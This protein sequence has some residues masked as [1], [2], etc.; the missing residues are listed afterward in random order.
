ML[1]ACR[2]YV[3]SRNQAPALIC[4]VMKV[5]HWCDFK[6]W[7]VSPKKCYCIKKDHLLLSLFLQGGHWDP[8]NPDG[9]FNPSGILFLSSASLTVGHIKNRRKYWQHPD[10][11]V[12]AG[13]SWSCFHSSQLML[14]RR[15]TFLKDDPMTLRWCFDELLFA[16]AL[17]FSVERKSF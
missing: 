6:H 16:R 5:W 15:L 7:T 4:E 1:T 3:V 17:S 9:I 12:P 11:N 10:P 14:E 8:T 13:T 2:F